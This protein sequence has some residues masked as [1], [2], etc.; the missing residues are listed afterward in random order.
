MYLN[1]LNSATHGVNK[2]NKILSSSYG[3]EIN[4]AEMSIPSLRK[5]L[6]T[7]ES[8]MQR[9][10]ESDSAYWDNHQF[11]KLKLIREQLELYITEVAPCRKDNKKMKRR[12]MREGVDTDLESA[13]V[14]LAAQEIVDKLQGIV[15]DLAKMQVQELMPIVDSMKEHVGFDVAEQYSSAAETALSELLDQAKSAKDALENATLAAQGKPVNQTSA[16]P[17]TVMGMGPDQGPD[18]MGPPE[19]EFG[20]DT[21]MAGADNTIGREL[22]T[23]SFSRMERQAN[24]QLRVLEAKRKVLEAATNGKIP[25]SE[26]K[27]IIRRL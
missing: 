7:T 11:N 2:L 25:T 15:E 6:G 13:E 10:R 17:E 12:K 5:M 24:A 21:A 1:D 4:L 19:D 16:A 26:L 8:K 27:K 23:E 14:L 3:H 20:G 18:E 22:K 9:I